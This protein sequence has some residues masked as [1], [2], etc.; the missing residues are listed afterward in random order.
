MMHPDNLDGI[1]DAVARWEAA[2]LELR[3]A[4]A[5][6][7]CSEG[8]HLIEGEDRVIGE[9]VILRCLNTYLDS[10]QDLMAA[11]VLALLREQPTG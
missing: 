9:A 5:Q 2:T 4:L 7:Y 1:Y 6:T 11:S 3:A 8:Y 10:S